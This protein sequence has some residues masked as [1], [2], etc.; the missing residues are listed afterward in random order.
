MANCLAIVIADNKDMCKQTG[1]G[2]GIEP[3]IRLQHWHD[4]T[5]P[6]RLQGVWAG[7]PVPS[8]AL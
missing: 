6:D 5:V 7:A 8:V 4:F 1:R 3:G 2:D